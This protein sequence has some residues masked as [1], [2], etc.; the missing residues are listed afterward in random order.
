MAIQL[1]TKAP[2]ALAPGSGEVMSWFS[3]GLILKASAP[4]LGVVE[5]VINPGDE[6]P[7][8]IHSR[9]D[10]WFYVLEGEMTF[11]VGGDNHRVAAGAFV[12]FP[13][14]IAH[15]F[16]IE[17]PSARALIVNT[18]GGFEQM[19]R[20]SPK[21]V[22]EAVQALTDYGMEVVGPHPRDVASA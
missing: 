6:P 8:H 21:N 10:E 15:T 3:S 19:F 9:E 4:E 20:R 18:P 7:L 12:S 13:R 17:S 14:G 22:E 2:Y 1:E 11:H 5:A 16:T